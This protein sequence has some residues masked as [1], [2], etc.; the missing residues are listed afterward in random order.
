MFRWPA[1]A[2][3]LFVASP[4]FSQAPAAPVDIETVRFSKIATAI[5]IA[6]EISIDGRLDEGPWKLAIAATDFYN[7]QHQG[8]LATEQTEARFLYDDD[9]L[10]VGIVCF[11]SDVQHRVVNDLKE[12]YNI[13][14]T[15]SLSVI[16]DSLNDDRSGFLFGTTPAGARRDAQISNDRTINADWDG[17]WDV[18]VSINENNWTAEFVIPF[19]TLRFSN[20]TTQE[21]GMNVT[22]RLLRKTEES[23]WAPMPLRGPTY[24]VSFSGTL[25]GLENIRQGRNLKV[26]PFM[27]AG[28]TQSRPATEPSGPLSTD[29]DYD[30]GV[31]L[32]YSITPSMTL[33]ATYRT[34]FAQ[35]EADQQQVNLTRFNLFFPEKREFFLENAGT[36]GFGD[37]ARNSNLVPF[38]SRRIGLD[39]GGAPIPILGGTRVSGQMGRYDAGLL[40]MKTQHLGSTPSNNYLVGRLKRNLFTR[41]WIGGLVTDRESTLPG[42]YNR[43]YGADARFVFYDR[44]EFD[45]YL[46]KSDTPGREGN[47]QARRFK[48]A[49][50]DDE[51]VAGAEYNAVQPNF[52]PEVGFIRRDDIEHYAGE[53]TWKPRL[54]SSDAVRNLTMGTQLAYFGSSST[55]KVETRTQEVNLGMLFENNA[56]IDFAAVQT[57]DRLIAPVR[58]RGIRVA[59]G[60]YDYLGYSA[61]FNTDQSEKIGGSGS[62]DWGEFWN[63]RR[64]SVAAGLTVKPD[65]RFSL[66]L[67][68]RRDK[69]ALTEG[70]STTDLIG[71]R[72]IYG[73]GPKSFFNGFLQYNG[74]THEISTNIRFNIMYRPLSDLY[75]VFNDRRSTDRGE[76]IERAF[77]IKL[78]N[79]ISF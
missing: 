74:A 54:E 59:P 72:F 76:V 69:V 5:R 15:D 61:S 40:A 34:D 4:A 79:L 36:F 53:F 13:R 1:L 46:L 71:A 60:D 41:S 52:N 35:V 21:W 51:L 70:S 38:F 55:G 75:L 58:I 9:N 20:A 2:L 26:K 18:R 66:A 16:L 27:T 10:Y 50:V 62:I 31:D 32:K 39:A 23:M 25:R 8:E 29:Q 7:W 65:V 64:R 33:D 48:T 67:D 17:V 12:D 47:D 24:R 30:G 19:K 45:S 11:D 28:F 56:S 42:D 63:G 73:F 77:I 57:F 14:D 78:T 43:V 37:D 3:C 68:Y 44:L 6:D 49:W 22:R